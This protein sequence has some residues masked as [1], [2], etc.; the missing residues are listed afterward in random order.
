M[1]RNILLPYC[2]VM[3]AA[4]LITG[5]ATT[6]HVKV[7]ED[8]NVEAL[9][10]F[11]RTFNPADY[12]PEIPFERTDLEKILPIPEEPTEVSSVTEIVSGFRV[13]VSFTDNIE[14]AS[15]IKNDVST[16][17][18]DQSV[19]VVYE[20][21]YY[22]VRVGDFLNRPEAN[23]TLRELVERGYKDAWVVP[24]KVRRQQE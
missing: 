10:R 3:L 4:F 21:P 23:I 20:A 15:K 14:H 5:C 13:Q 12:D 6:E 18:A 1:K 9:N 24:D 19:Y 11:E 7:E 8:E 16:L 17:F 22:K 2:F